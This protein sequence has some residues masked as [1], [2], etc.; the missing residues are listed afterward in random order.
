MVLC[1]SVWVIKCLSFLLVPS[2]NPSMPLYPKMLRARERALNSLLFCY[3]TSYSH[4]SL[5][6]HLGTCQMSLKFWKMMTKM[7]PFKT[8][9]V[10]HIKF[11]SI[12]PSHMHMWSFPSLSCTKFWGLLKMNII[13]TLCISW[14]EN[15]IIIW[16]PILTYVWNVFTKKFTT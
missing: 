3:F 10:A 14:R 8:Y 15:S 1:R 13:S 7:Q 16:L 4:L 11:L 2:R 9:V 12:H 5:S 6:R